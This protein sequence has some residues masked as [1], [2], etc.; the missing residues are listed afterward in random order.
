MVVPIQE[1]ERTVS[2]VAIVASVCRLVG[3]METWRVQAYEVVGILPYML[4][5]NQACQEQTGRGRCRTASSV[6]VPLV[7]PSVCRWHKG[8]G[9][10]Y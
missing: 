8:L 2:V 5:P 7:L 10:S 6:A 4:R 9:F 1:E 3:Q